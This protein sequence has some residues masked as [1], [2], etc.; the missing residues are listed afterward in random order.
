M[1]RALL[2]TALGVTLALPAAAGAAAEQP[3]VVDELVARVGQKVGLFL[4]DFSSVK[5]TEKVT[6]LRL[7]EKGKTISTKDSAYDY[8]VMFETSAGD[9]QFQESRLLMKEA[10]QQEKASLLVTNGFSALLLVFHPEFQSSFRYEL[11]ADEVS[12]GRTLKRIHFHHIRGMRSPLGLL[13]KNR[14]FPMELD[15]EAWVDSATGMVARM[16]ATLSETLE[17]IGMRRFHAEVLYN[18]VKFSSSDAALWLPA[19]AQI[20]LASA[21]NQW[22]NFHRFTEYKLFSVKTETQ[23]TPP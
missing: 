10:A 15:G 19:S 11:G 7:N 16:E 4:E 14:E 22:K 13:L 6:Q 17:D 23:V 3:T 1:K 21:K 9:V 8:L 12:G 18:P 5:C 20:E 2:A